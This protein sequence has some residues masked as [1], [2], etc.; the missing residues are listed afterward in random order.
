MTPERR[1]HYPVS[2]MRIE[3]VELDLDELDD[4][5]ESD[6]LQDAIADLVSMEV[7]PDWE[8]EFDRTQIT[9]RVR[10]ALRANRKADK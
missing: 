8:Y 2:I 1:T 9:N 5:T 7:G 4:M 10:A 3:V 6:A